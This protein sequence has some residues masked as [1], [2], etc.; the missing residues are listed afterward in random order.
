[1]ESQALEH[2]LRIARPTG[3]EGVEVHSGEADAGRLPRR[4]FSDYTLL[5]ASGAGSTVVESG[6]RTETIPEN[7][8]VM[9]EP[10]TVLS[11]SSPQPYSYRALFISPP[12]FAGLFARAPE[13]Q[14]RMVALPQLYSENAVVVSTFIAAHEALGAARNP[15]EAQIALLKLIFGLLGA[16]LVRRPAGSASHPAVI[17][18]ARDHIRGAYTRGMTLDE[19]S[20]RVGMCKYALVRAFTREFGLPPHTYQTYLRVM[21]ARSLI[22]EGRQISDV[23]L[24]VG[25]TDQSHLNRHFKR[26]LGY[27]PGSYARQVS[28]GDAKRARRA[29]R[30]RH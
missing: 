3:V 5:V 15:V 24:E 6:H 12:A 26:M 10:E 18:R 2:P 22:R 7:A 30:A 23:A 19:L 8:L 11:I 16:G 20:R 29:A 4:I 14:S 28:G 21:L 9:V 13:D 27:T 17:S 25:F 1:M